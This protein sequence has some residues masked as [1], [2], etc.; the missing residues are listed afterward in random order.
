MRMC[1]Q[2]TEHCGGVF[3]FVKKKK[4]LRDF[5]NYFSLF[6]YTY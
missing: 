5:L 6:C 4:N 2:H 3:D 1:E